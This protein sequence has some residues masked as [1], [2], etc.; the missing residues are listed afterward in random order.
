MKRLIPISLTG[1]IAALIVVAS[2]CPTFAQEKSAISGDKK[3]PAVDLAPAKL[4]DNA[5]SEL[6]DNPVTFR[7]IA[8]ARR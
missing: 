6:V 2:R 3:T 5:Q 1:F 4:P 8:Q 7:L